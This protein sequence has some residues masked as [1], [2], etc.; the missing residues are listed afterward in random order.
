MKEII[1]QLKDGLI[2][3]D[4]AL[5]KIL[6]LVLDP[7]YKAPSHDPALVDANTFYLYIGQ[8]DENSPL[9]LDVVRGE[10]DVM[11]RF[12]ILESQYNALAAV[13]VEEY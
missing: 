1:Q 10:D 2:T 4:E 6:V 11:H 7:D 3:D 13:G 12:H 9:M 8:D 5:N